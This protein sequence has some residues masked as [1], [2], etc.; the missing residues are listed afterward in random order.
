M[1]FIPLLIF[2]FVSMVLQIVLDFKVWNGSNDYNPD[3]WLACPFV[4][5]TVQTTVCKA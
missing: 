5:S 4:P 3:T 1:R 2:T